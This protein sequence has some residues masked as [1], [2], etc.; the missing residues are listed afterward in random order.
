MWIDPDRNPPS[1]LSPPE[2]NRVLVEFSPDVLWIM[3]MD[4]R[5]VYLSPSVENQ[6]GWTPEEYLAL[7]PEVLLPKESLDRLEALA[8]E[9]RAELASPGGIVPGRLRTFEMLRRH[10]DGRLLW[11]EVKA[12]IFRDSEGRPRGIHGATRNIED[13]K[14]LERERL[15][16]EERHRQ[17]VEMLPIGVFECDLEGRIKYLNEAMYRMFLYP[18]ETR[19]VE[20]SIP[21]V[22]VPEDWE[23]VRFDMARRL[24]DAHRPPGAYTGL[25]M[26]GTKIPIEVHSAV[27]EKDGRPLG[28]RGVIIDSSDK[29]RY[30]AEL[31][32]SNKLDAL[33]L[34]AGGIAHDFNNMLAAVMGNI[35]LAGLEM[36]DILAGGQGLP[37]ARSA[38]RLL[39]EAELAI[40][41]ARDL[42]SRLLT[43]SRGG[44][45]VKEA[46]SLE[47]LVAELGNFN[48]AG[49]AC[50]FELLAAPKLPTIM[51]DRSQIAQ[52]IQNLV[53]NAVQA[54]PE[55]GV[56][57]A[58]L[59]I[60]EGRLR[61]DVDDEGPGV[62]EP[63]RTSIFDPYFTTKAR[64]SGLGLAVCLAVA[65]GH[66]GDISVSDSPRGGARF[67]VYLPTGFPG[68]CLEDLGG[69]KDIL[70]TPGL[71]ILFVDDEA[72]IRKV[73]AE[74]AGRLG[75]RMVTAADLGEAVS[76]WTGELGRSGHIDLAIV[77]LTIR[78]GPGGLE[79]LS[80][81]R[82]L[83][84]KLPVL[85]SSGYS[86]DPVL[87]A[88]RRAGFSGLLRK[89][90]DLQA[91]VLAVETAHSTACQDRLGGVD[92]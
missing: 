8:Q 60:E 84:P 11:G 80:R 18:E 22:I 83:D 38:E 74:M 48:T 62:A 71:S 51:A 7:A 69:G 39:H 10:K 46:F 36:A 85:V 26:D 57:R 2:I 70:A 64:G 14:E 58:S 15:E 42:T 49:S 87:S 4:F 73:A 53:I 59:V 41:R 50:R 92:A 5:L 16:V 52:L 89:P 28:F 3:D 90:Y 47:T 12:G 82:D 31:L 27:I 88:W 76:A 30:E 40:L 55:G 75:Y 17:L 43:F 34:L 66:G 81:L 25:R 91:F 13:R 67:T 37:E 77:D 86:E 19:G 24:T 45:P 44:S 78:G 9:L 68:D 56:V 29:K 79:I 54:M 35:N 1:S 21:Q 6:L 61:L 72:P 63:L 32:K 20:L 23:R 65:R 33:G